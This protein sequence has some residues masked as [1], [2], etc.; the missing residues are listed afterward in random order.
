MVHLLLLL[1]ACRSEP[2]P[3]PSPTSMPMPTGASGTASDTGTPP[4]DT[5][6]TGDPTGLIDTG[7]SLD[8]AWIADDEV[9][10]RITVTWP[11]RVGEAVLSWVDDSGDH[12]RRADAAAGVLVVPGLPASSDIVWSV[13]LYD[14]ETLLASSGSQVDRIADPPEG[15]V[16]WQATVHDPSA[17][18]LD[19]WFLTIQFDFGASGDSYAVVVD[20]AGRLRW[21]RAAE[22]ERR[23]P[24]AH[25]SADGA[26]ILWA[27]NDADRSEEA[28]F[29]VREPIDGSP[30]VVTL[31][32]DLHHDFVES[33][34]G[35]DYLAHVYGTAELGGGEMP[36]ATDAIRQVE[37]G[38]S[39]LYSD[40]FDFF[41]DWPA[42][43]SQPCSHSTLDNFVPGHVEWTHGNSLVAAADGDG[44]WILARYL[45]QIGRVDS[46]GQLLG[47]LGGDDPTW[48]GPPDPFVHGHFSHITPEG[49]LLVF[50]NGDHVHQVEGSRVVEL[51]VDEV[52]GTVSTVWET[53]E[54]EGSFVGFLGDA[55]RLP[56]G[57]TLVVNPNKGV[58]E[59]APDGEVRFELRHDTPTNIG[60]VE[61]IAPW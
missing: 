17:E 22:P 57:D 56:G 36:V 5:A 18:A 9:P 48:A 24:R 16:P 30:S 38:A 53:P 61:P 7:E 54:P 41:S 35:Y 55:I 44:W 13:E 10:T 32:P 43:P 14:G 46:S 50:S 34:D 23:L 45:D 21:W 2:S 25:L 40:A 49:H 3:S 52:A 27:S 19:H 51:A 15:L 39:G 4:D 47:I 37:L 58:F 11:P 12:E 31:A 1:L 33:D 60:R 8:A 59:V 42:E 20:A 29:I 6:A 26:A 28:G